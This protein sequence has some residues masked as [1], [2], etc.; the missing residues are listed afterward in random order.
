M[1]GF[2]SKGDS[3]SAEED[4]AGRGDWLADGGLSRWSAISVEATVPMLS[5]STSVQ[6]RI[7]I[8][9]PSQ[10]IQLNHC[11]PRRSGSQWQS[12]AV[13]SRRHLLSSSC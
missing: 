7:V 10:P 11:T 2:S 12:T 5:K 6:S 4:V 1:D 3:E 9:V 8:V 13:Q